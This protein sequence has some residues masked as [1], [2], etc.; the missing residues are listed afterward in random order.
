MSDLLR[1]FV[2]SPFVFGLLILIV[3]QVLAACLVAVK[4]KNF[5]LAYLAD[6]YQIRIVPYIGGLGIVYILTRWLPVEAMGPFRSYIN[7][8]LFAVC[9]GV[10]TI[11]LLVRLWRDLTALGLPLPKFEAGGERLPDR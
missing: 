3:C 2:T 10:L 8:G 4:E 5:D 11:T 7:D 6:F 1:G 9:W